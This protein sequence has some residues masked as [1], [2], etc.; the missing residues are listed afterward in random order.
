MNKLDRKSNLNH[1]ITTYLILATYSYVRIYSTI[2]LWYEAKI[3]VLGHVWSSYTGCLHS[4]RLIKQ[5]MS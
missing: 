2:K 3:S 1:A 4:F 5:N